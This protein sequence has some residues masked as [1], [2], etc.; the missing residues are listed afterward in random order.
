MFSQQFTRQMSTSPPPFSY[1]T[2]PTA[3]NV[4]YATYQQP[5]SYCN[6]PGNGMD[7]PLYPQYLPPVQQ[8]YQHIVPS[9]GNT[10]IKQEYYNDDDMSPFSMSYASMAGVDVS[11]AQS[12]QDVPAY[13]SIKPHHPPFQRSYSYPQWP[14]NTG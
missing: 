12:Y 4:S 7:M 3:E 1:G 8:S 14:T 11:S 9:M 5:A 13:V 2:V 6:M 10:P